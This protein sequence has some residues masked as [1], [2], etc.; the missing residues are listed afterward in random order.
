MQVNLIFFRVFFLNFTSLTEFLLLYMRLDQEVHTEEKPFNSNSTVII[1]I[2]LPFHHSP[3]F[4]Q[5][6]NRL[7][8]FKGRGTVSINRFKIHIPVSVHS[9]KCCL[10]KFLF[11]TH[12]QNFNLLEQQ[13]LFYIYHLTRPCHFPTK[14]MCMN[15]T[16]YVPSSLELLDLVLL[17]RSLIYYFAVATALE[18]G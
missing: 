7:F 9:C 1:P 13:K 3:L 6:Q 14:H 12:E 17:S 4:S 18:T 10:I 5:L 11:L 15:C 16:S 2:P 8:T